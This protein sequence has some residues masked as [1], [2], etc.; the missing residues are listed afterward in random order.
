MRA[1]RYRRLGRSIGGRRGGQQVAVLVAS[2]KEKIMRKLI[3]IFCASILFLTF[4]D[5]ANA[6]CDKNCVGLCNA[7]ANR[8]YRGT[9]AQCIAQYSCPSY[10]G[11]QCD[12]EVRVTE[13]A[14]RINAQRG[15]DRSTCS[16]N[17][18]ICEEGVRGRGRDPA[19]QSDCPAAY[20][21]CMQTGIWQTSG[22]YG[23]T[24]TGVAKR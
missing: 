6:W 9:A 12:P 5:T 14:N 4:A 18:R 21:R 17:L 16:G 1:I 13:R 20:R 22:S 2:T 19:T 23:R 3:L 11:Q 24:E 10:A 8:G 7:I 15:N